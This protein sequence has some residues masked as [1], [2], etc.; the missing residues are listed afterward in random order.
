MH[1]PLGSLLPPDSPKPSQQH[2]PH[3]HPLP[4]PRTNSDD[5]EPLRQIVTCGAKSGHWAAE[6]GRTLA[7]NWTRTTIQLWN[8]DSLFGK[9]VAILS[10]VFGLATLAFV[11]YIAVLLLPLFILAIFVAL[12]LGLYSFFND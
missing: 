2:S 6:N 10:A 12:V 8:R 4:R 11:A 9:T 1:P 3:R 5:F 7:T